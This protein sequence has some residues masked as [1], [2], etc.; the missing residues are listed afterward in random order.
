[1][2]LNDLHL[3]LAEES[4][5]VRVYER[6]WDSVRY[7]EEPHAQRKILPV[8]VTSNGES[9]CFRSAREAFIEHGIAE[10]RLS[11]VMNYLKS[12][13]VNVEVGDGIYLLFERCAL[14]SIEEG[15]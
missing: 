2:S 10:S 3:R 14:P 8:R 11:N 7:T 15:E 9:R 4:N 13:P 6:D 5:G 12:G 1:M